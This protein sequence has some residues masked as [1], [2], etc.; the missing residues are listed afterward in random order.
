M[1]SDLIP[2]EEKHKFKLTTEGNSGTNLTNKD[3]TE[4]GLFDDLSKATEIS[5][6]YQ[7]IKKVY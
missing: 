7:K 1:F 2:S 6:K 5:L 3:K 4:P